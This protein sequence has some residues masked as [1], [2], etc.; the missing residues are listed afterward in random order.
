M[1]WVYVGVAAAT[2][3]GGVMANDA[4]KDASKSQQKGAAAAADA[5]VQSAQIA[6]DV[7]REFYNQTRADYTPQ[8]A[9]G[10]KALAM[11][12]QSYGISPY[13]SE[14]SAAEDELKSLDARLQ[15]LGSLARPTAP[16]VAP[17]AVPRKKKKKGLGSKLKKAAG[18]WTGAS[19]VGA[20]ANKLGLP[21]LAG[22][23]FSDKSTPSSNPEYAAA[24]EEYV[25]NKQAYRLLS[26]Q[27]RALSNRI[28]SLKEQAA[29][30]VDYTQM[31]EGFYNSPDYQFA[32][33]QGNKAAQARLAAIGLRDS[34]RAVKETGRFNQGLATQ[35]LSEYRNGLARLA[36]VGQTATQDVS[37][38]GGS[39]ASN[40]GNAA[41]QAGDA[42]ASSYL[43]AGRA[44][45]DYAVNQSN[46]YQNLLGQGA[47]LY[48]M[49]AN[50]PQG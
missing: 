12:G 42:R 30:P 18:V 9:T 39:A 21:T 16:P 27:R 36:G 5:S 14:L 20:T 10:N 48:G 19:L 24:L 35:T 45:G 4:A 47:Y 23:V 31:Y 2:V 13:V 11:L 29:Q 38:Q 43:A 49:Y 1:S 6:A 25:K 15:G 40:I 26:E 33:D 28:G 17:V 32:Y 7:Q 41:L 37:S 3:V 34:G 22:S 8:R 44:Q 50:R 46:N